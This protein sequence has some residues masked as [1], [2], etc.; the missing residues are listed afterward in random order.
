M[1]IAEQRRVLVADRIW[2]AAALLH[3]KHP[4][5]RDFSKN[6]ILEMAASEGLSADIERGTLNAHLDQHL[7]ANVP[8]SSGKYRMLFETSPGNLRLFRPGDLTHPGRIQLRKA[9][10][11]IPNPHEIPERYHYLL[12]WY[13]NWSKQP[14]TAEPVKRFEDDPLIRLIGSGKQTWADEHADEYVDRLRREDR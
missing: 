13:T 1:A 12:D 2:I 10:K 8:P 5:R 9:S 7:V 4:A 14:R 6:E 11:V 3:K